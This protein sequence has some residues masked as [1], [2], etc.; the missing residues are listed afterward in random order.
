MKILV[1]TKDG[2]QWHEDLKMVDKWSKNMRSF[3]NNG[4]AFT[5]GK[6]SF[7]T[8][9][10]LKGKFAVFVLFSQKVIVIQ[11]SALHH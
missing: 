10:F 5:L 8:P 11:K 9:R 6:V 1:I 2:K 3:L 7:R 4:K